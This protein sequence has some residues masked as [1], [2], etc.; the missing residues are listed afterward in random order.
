MSSKSSTP[1]P[2]HAREAA[3]ALRPPVR[4]A[5]QRP[6]LVRLPLKQTLDGY[7]SVHMIFE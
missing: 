4:R 6:T 3:L 2:P 5:W 1:R 7:G